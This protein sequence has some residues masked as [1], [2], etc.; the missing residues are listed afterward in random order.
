MDEKE[1]LN[2]FSNGY[3]AEVLLI[4]AF[5]MTKISQVGFFYKIG[6]NQSYLMM[7]LESSLGPSSS[8]FFYKRHLRRGSVVPN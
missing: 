8:E 6:M 5:R 4:I 1:S 7:R 3:L 2:S